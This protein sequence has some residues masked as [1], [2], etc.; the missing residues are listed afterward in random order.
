[1]A[2]NFRT[3]LELGHGHGQ[4]LG[5]GLGMCMMWGRKGER[6]RDENQL[7]L[8]HI[9]PKRTHR[10]QS[11]ERGCNWVRLCAEKFVYYRIF[12]QLIYWLRERE[13]ESGNMRFAWALAALVTLL[14]VWGRR[15]P[16]SMVI[17]DPM[18]Q[19]EF[20]KKQRGESVRLSVLIE[21]L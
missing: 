19:M 8:R 2:H 5:L 1:M 20:W 21:L 7:S 17:V 13:T 10:K 18:Q 4:R 15:T 16:P 9:W 3:R 11:R 6:E 14:T 12:W